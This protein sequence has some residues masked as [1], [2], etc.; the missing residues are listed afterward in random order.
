MR[1]H[2]KIRARLT[3]PTQPQRP[4]QRKRINRNPGRIGSD[5]AQTEEAVRD[6]A[7]DQLDQHSVSEKKRPFAQIKALFRPT[8]IH[9]ERQDDV[10][11]QVRSF[12]GERNV[13][14][15]HGLW[16]EREPG[17]GDEGEAEQQAEAGAVAA[18]NGHGVFGRVRVF[19]RS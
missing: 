13:R 2:R 12:V 17:G 16:R 7:L 10:A 9:Q 1:C 15:R 6:L 3:N 5:I 19:H 14:K 4:L 18:G 11:Q 8:G